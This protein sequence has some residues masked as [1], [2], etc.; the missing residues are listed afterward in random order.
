MKRKIKIISH[1]KLSL[2][3][4]RPT[5]LVRVPK[6]LAQCNLNRR[7]KLVVADLS[8]HKG[9]SPCV[10]PANNLA[11]KKMIRSGRILSKMEK[12]KRKEKVSSYAL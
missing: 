4:C 9:T 5:K 7:R 10:Q 8:V 3:L 12:E 6:H 11:C 1:T 2:P